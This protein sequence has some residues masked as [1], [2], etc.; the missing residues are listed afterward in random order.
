VLSTWRRNLLHKRNFIPGTVDS[1][2]EPTVVLLNGHVVKLL[3][4]VY[5]YTYRFAL[6]LALV[7]EALFYSQWQLM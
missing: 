7:R 6:L 1:K 5:G 2:E 3:C 4:N